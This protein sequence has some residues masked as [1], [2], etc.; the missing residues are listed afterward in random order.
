MES[1]RKN[2]APYGRL[3]HAEHALDLIL[4]NP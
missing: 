4:T 1:A 3:C 2:D